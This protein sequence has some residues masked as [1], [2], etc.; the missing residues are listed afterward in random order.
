MIPKNRSHLTQDERCQIFVL[1]KSGKSLRGIAKL[2][3][4]SHTTI[5]REIQRNANILGRYTVKQAQKRAIKR[6]YRANSRPKKMNNQ[7]IS[8][9]QSQLNETRASPEQ[10]SGR[11]LTKHTIKVSFLTIYRFIAKDKRAGGS[12]FKMLRHGRKKYRKNIN[13]AAGRGLIPNRIDIDQRPKI[14]DE[15]RRTGDFEVD[16]IIGKDHKGTIVSMVDRATKFTRLR[17]LKRGTA[18]AVS[19]AIIEKLRPLAEINL[20]HTITSDNGKEFSMHEHISI[21]LLCSFYF[22]KPYHSW[23]RGLNEHT[24]GLIRQHFPKGTDFT[25][26]TDEDVKSVEWMLNNRPRKSLN[27]DTPLERMSQSVALMGGGA[28]RS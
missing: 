25:K 5:V 11:L 23:E 15:K 26:L 20:V 24:N 10:I 22:A 16:Q 18:Q 4:R 3:G 7:L 8:M 13:K 9:I 12:L 6:K 2:L 1:L 21:N 19:S 17:L 28:F 27:F 14:V